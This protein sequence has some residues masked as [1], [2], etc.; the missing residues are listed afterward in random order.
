MFRWFYTQVKK[1]LDRFDLS[2]RKNV[3]KIF[4]IFMQIFIQFLSK[5]M[6]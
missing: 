4:G 2:W 6:T 1:F 3:A 5:D